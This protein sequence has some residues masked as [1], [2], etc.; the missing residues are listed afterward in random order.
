MEKCLSV[1]Y[2]DL[3]EKDISQLKKSV[4]K[5]LELGSIE[6]G[7]KLLNMERVS[8]SEFMH[9]LKMVLEETHESSRLRWNDDL[10][11][12]AW[13]KV[14]REHLQNA[15]KNL[16]DNALKYDRNGGP[17]DITTHKTGDAVIFGI[18]DHGPGINKADQEAIF[19]KFYRINNSDAA[20]RGYGL[21]L[22]YTRQVVEM[23]KGRI[24]VNSVSGK[25]STFSIELP[26]AA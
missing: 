4:D 10:E 20:A 9:D 23:M 7:G 2:L 17:V 12:E 8:T 25:G 26:I 11:G 1:K 22:S 19:A 24:L 13:I 18:K 21:G 3:I 5:V 16:I 6:H 14:D 15:L